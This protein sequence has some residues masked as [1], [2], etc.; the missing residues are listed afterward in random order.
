MRAQN[1][2]ENGIGPARS[3]VYQPSPR[4]SSR[5]SRARKISYFKPLCDTVL[6]RSTMSEF[7]DILAKCRDKSCQKEQDE[8]GVGG[9][10]VLIVSVDSRRG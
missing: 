10:V 6:H 7:N 5:L 8:V 3:I 9:R 1:G 4:A 2:H